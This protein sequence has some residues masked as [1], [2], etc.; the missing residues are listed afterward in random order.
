[1]SSSVLDDPR[2][3]LS[4][5]GIRNA[6]D[7]GGYRTRDGRSVR[8]GRVYRS[9]A[10]GGATEQDRMLLRQR[11]L[12]AVCDLRSGPERVA[13]PDSW[14]QQAG[15]TLWE[16][17][18]QEAV[19]DSRELLANSLVSAERTRAVMA[20][21]YRQMPFIQTV[22]FGALFRSLIRGDLPLLFH[23]SAGKDRSGGAAALLLLTLGVERETVV[24]DYL[25]SNRAWETLCRDYVDDPRH[26]AA[27]EHVSRP[28]LPLLDA[29]QH[30]LD[31][32]LDALFAR[33]D[34][35]ED[36]LDVELG[37]PRAAVVELRGRL[38]E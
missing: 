13:A 5:G 33:Y 12:R 14:P 34:T 35:V 28:W 9:G 10:I 1:M 17:P 31:A 6:R 4:L 20:E 16:Q 8:W 15:I 24:A 38:L 7:L 26:R 25:L 3:H 21:A 37:I 11:G 27:L 36:Y 18:E 22:A 2:R 29:D 23:C 32:L 30:Y 19:G